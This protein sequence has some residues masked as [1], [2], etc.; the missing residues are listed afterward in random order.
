MSLICRMSC[1]GV[2]GLVGACGKVQD[3][4]GFS[5]TA[6]YY[7]CVRTTVQRHPGEFNPV[8]SGPPEYRWLLDGELLP[9][10]FLELMRD[11]RSEHECVVDPHSPADCVVYIVCLEPLCWVSFEGPF[12]ERQFWGI[13]AAL[14]RNIGVG[15]T[16]AGHGEAFLWCP[17]VG[18]RG[19]PLG[20]GEDIDLGQD[21]FIRLEPVEL[22]DPYGGEQYK[23]AYS[24]QIVCRGEEP[25]VLANE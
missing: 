24:V 14:S 5:E 7:G 3:L 10:R 18:V 17:D 23:A 11:V 12:V 9:H 22:T 16:V 8:K 21:L 15:T 6:P 20:A 19:R 13:T 25:S 1:V 4:P 2:L